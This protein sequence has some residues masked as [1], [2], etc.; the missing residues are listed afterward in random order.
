MKDVVLSICGIAAFLYYLFSEVGSDTYFLAIAGINLCIFIGYGWVTALVTLAGFTAWHS[1]N[2]LS[3][4]LID[5]LVLPCIAAF[6][7]FYAVIRI[8]LLQTTFRGR[9]M[10]YGGFDDSGESE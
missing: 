10:S 9:P 3:E 8:H 7:L 2:F 5:F 6:C 1:S 4:S